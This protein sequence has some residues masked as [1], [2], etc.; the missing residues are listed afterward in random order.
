MFQVSLFLTLAPKAMFQ[1]TLLKEL[2]MDESLV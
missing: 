1:D 2:A